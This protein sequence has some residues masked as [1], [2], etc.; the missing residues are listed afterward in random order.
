VTAAE[1][2]WLRREAVLAI[3]A[4]QLSEH[5]GLTG[6][7]DEGLLDAALARPRQLWS[8]ETPTPDIARLAA[9]YA[10]AI[11]RNHPF[12]DGN[13]RTAYVAMRT[14]LIGNGLDLTASREDRYLTIMAGAAGDLDEPSFIGSVRANT[15]ST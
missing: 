14:F 3:H 10:W 5:G 12:S 13:K 9:T 8:C 15:A 1:P 6:M 11:L 2:R 7:R 4:R